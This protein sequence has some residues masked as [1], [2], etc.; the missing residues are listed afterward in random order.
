MNEIFITADRST[1]PVLKRNQAA[2]CMKNF[3]VHFVVYSQENYILKKIIY[4]LVNIS[5]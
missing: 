3:Q 2:K 1:W 5:S 4:V